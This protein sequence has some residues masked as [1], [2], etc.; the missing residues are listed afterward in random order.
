MPSPLR[1]ALLTLLAIRPM[2]GYDV[3]RTYQRAMQQIWYAPIGQ[4]YPRLRAMHAEGFLD[5]DVHVQHDRPNRKVYRLTQAGEQQ[6]T[7]WLDQPAALPRMH[8]EFIHKLFVLDRMTRNR[9]SQFIE[10]YIQT[11]STWARQLGEVDEKFSNT[12]HGEYTESAAFQVLALRHL[13]RLVDTEIASAHDI[14]DQLED[15]PAA[16]RGRSPGNGQ[17]ALWLAD[18]SAMPPGEQVADESGEGST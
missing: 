2:S 18:L 3:R 5:A 11:C 15:T 16:T 8:H 6:L 17:P 14:L 10:D 4:V 9:R 13:R 12:P 7:G 1:E